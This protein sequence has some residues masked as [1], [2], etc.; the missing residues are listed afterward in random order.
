MTPKETSSVV[1]PAALSPADAE[2]IRLEALERLEGAKT[3]GAVSLDVD[4]AS[5]TPCA[6]QILIATT[7]TAE[8]MGVTLEISEQGKSA[9]AEL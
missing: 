7:R 9:L 5:L 6:L 3:T 1:I 4:G 2:G 8:R